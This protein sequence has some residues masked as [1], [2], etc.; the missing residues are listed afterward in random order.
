MR[1]LIPIIAIMA[2]LL[3]L[4]ACDRHYSHNSDDDVGISNPVVPAGGS[5]FGLLNQFDHAFDDTRNISSSG[6]EDGFEF[7]LSES[8]VVVITA[9][10]YGGF[11]AFLD[12]YD[13]NF[14]FI[15]GD[16]NGGPSP[17]PAIVGTLGAGDYFVVVGGS[18]SSTG[19]YDIDIS[20]EPLGGSDF[21]V[22]VPTDSF[23]DNGGAIDDAFDVDSYIITVLTNV[24]GDFYVTTTF[25]S[26][27]G[28][29]EII[30][31][32]GSQLF[33]GD[34][35]GNADPAAINIALT[36]GTY[37]VRVGGSSGSGDYSMQIDVN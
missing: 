19:D 22:M 11:D 2:P 7:S 27:D 1:K 4:T 25:G 12:L 3:A 6:D 36:P 24:T 5:D 28:N 29:L 13:F 8:S 15:T 35:S 20:V 21:G 33:Y 34:P 10:G 14:N 31:E 9:T 37:I 26:F 32:Y 16:D 30:D 17:D 23:I 18:G